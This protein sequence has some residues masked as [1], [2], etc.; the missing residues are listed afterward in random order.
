MRSH[1]DDKAR[2]SW[3]LPSCRPQFDN[4]GAPT[5]HI[6]RTITLYDPTTRQRTQKITLTQ[7][8][9]AGAWWSEDLDGAISIWADGEWRIIGYRIGTELPATQAP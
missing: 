2:N 9:P 1:Y 6:K 8:S 7:A 5:G 3:A 4:S